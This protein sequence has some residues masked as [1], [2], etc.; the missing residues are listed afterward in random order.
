MANRYKEFE[1]LPFRSLPPAFQ[2]MLGQPT[3]VA[4][5][6]PSGGGQRRAAPT[7]ERRGLFDDLFESPGRMALASAGLS[8]ME[9]SG[10][11]NQVG[12]SMARAAKIGL[13]T[14]GQM[15]AAKEEAKQ[16]AAMGAATL[17]PSIM[18]GMTP[19]QR[20]L[21][22]ALPVQDRVEVAQA[23]VFG[24]DEEKLYELSP[25]ETLVTGSGDVR[26]RGEKRQEEADR[27][28]FQRA[29]GE[30]LALDPHTAE[31]ISRIP[32]PEQGADPMAAAA[33]L[34]KEFAGRDSVTG[35]DVAKVQYQTAV[36]A[37]GDNS[38][39]G[40]LNLIYAVAKTVDPNSVVREGEAVMVRNTASLPEQ[41]VGT[42]NYVL[43]GGKLSLPQ[44][45]ALMRTVERYARARYGAFRRDL[46]FYEG[47]ARKANLDP[48]MIFPDFGPEPEWMDQSSGSI[49]TREPPPPPGGAGG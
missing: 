33:T 10:A 14:Y 20:R 3:P 18:E 6:R 27:L 26:A 19:A 38:P 24:E 43:G 25:G 28:T 12:P 7:P 30:L 39:S 46:R 31:V 42:L 2:R 5:P 49:S 47:I 21:Y 29:G 15:R 45:K 16:A 41:V 37:M 9:S 40:D 13:N 8:M 34:R 36:G 17:D 48:T 11:P 22:A 4:P 32:D 1:D 23:R 44:R 35:W